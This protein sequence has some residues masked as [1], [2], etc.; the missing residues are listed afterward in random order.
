MI[1]KIVNLLRWVVYEY[2]KK[3][4]LSRYP[5]YQ[6]VH[7][8]VRNRY[9]REEYRIP[10]NKPQCPIYR[11]NR[12][13]GGCNIAP[14]CDHAVDCGCYGY[15]T[16][17]LGGNDFWKVK[18]KASEYYGIGRCDEEGKFDWDYYNKR[19]IERKNK[20]MEVI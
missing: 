14:S 8:H 13:C 6:C 12:C 9:K 17:R 10:P 2:D 16:A 4:S 7:V 5:I 19:V 15:T 18:H 11:D 3:N 1:K 20:S